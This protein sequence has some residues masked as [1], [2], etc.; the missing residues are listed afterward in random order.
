MRVCRYPSEEDGVPCGRGATW[1]VQRMPTSWTG[2]EKFVYV[3]DRH[4]RAWRRLLPYVYIESLD[5]ARAYPGQAFKTA[6]HETYRRTGPI[7][8]ELGGSNG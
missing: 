4:A 6:Y 7:A 3:C 2:A 5:T 1:I 8:H